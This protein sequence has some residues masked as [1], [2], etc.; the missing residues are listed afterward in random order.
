MFVDARRRCGEG[1]LPERVEL[2]GDCRASGQPRGDAPCIGGI[3]SAC[4]TAKAFIGAGDEK[5][6]DRE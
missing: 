4:A 1:T 3:A 2:K 5:K 6:K